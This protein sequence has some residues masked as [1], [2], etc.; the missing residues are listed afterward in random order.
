MTHYDLI[1]VGAGFGG[2]AAALT[3]AE[4]GA[5]VLLLEALNYPGGCASTFRRSGYHFEAGATLFSG[6]GPGQLFD[7]WICRHGLAVETEFLDPVVHFRTPE[8]ILSVDRNRDAFF[9]SLAH[10]PRTDPKAVAALERAQRTVADVLWEILDHP[11]WLPPLEAKSVWAHVL[12]S[13]RYAELLPFVGRSLGSLLM[14]WSV[15]PDAALRTY[16]DA[17]CQITIQCRS[18]EAEAPFALGTMDYYFR[19]TGHVRGGIGRLAW[20]LVQAI[21]Q[22]GQTVRF[23]QRVRSV[24]RKDSGWEV[25]ARQERYWAPRVIFNLLPQ[26][27][28]G[29]VHSGVDFSSWFDRTSNRVAES[30]GAAMVYF[31]AKVPPGM[32][33][34]ALHVELVQDAQQPL[35]E[36]NHLFC[37]ISGA[38]DTGRAPEGER[39]VTVSTHV[40]MKRLQAAE[41]PGRYIQMIHD[42]MRRGL[43][44][45]L[46]EWWHRRTFEMTAS[47]RTFHRFTGR[48]HGFVGGIPRRVGLHHYRGL[49]PRPF[50]PGLFLVG[51]SVFPGQS[52]LAT[53]IGGQRVAQ[54]ILRKAT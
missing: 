1:V 17:L 41:E 9:R 27:V 23:A 8:W 5:R 37:S 24:R 49:F 13:P 53:A 44:V 3:A 46:P 21:Q 22:M 33:D 16:L 10:L 32:G 15:A 40:P 19:G 29:L 2:L 35:L 52:T 43:D 28:Q 30:W 51:D 25:R 31:A 12:R 18:D 39:T 54:A 20:G 6:L 4:Q 11:G 50:A 38:A 34:E 7:R 36:G 42:R 14:R 48:S 45:L 47:P 26:D